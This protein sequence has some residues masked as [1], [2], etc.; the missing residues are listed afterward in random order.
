M[1]DILALKHVSRI[2]RHCREELKDSTVFLSGL[3]VLPHLMFS[4]QILA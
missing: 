4:A 2:L 3:R 1:T